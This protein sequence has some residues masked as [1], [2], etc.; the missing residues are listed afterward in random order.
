MRKFFAVIFICLLA[1]CSPATENNL[2]FYGSSDASAGAAIDSNSFIVAD[3]EENILKGYK[4]ED[5][6]KP[7]FGLDVSQ[8]LETTKE[9]P[10]AD[11][12]AAAK[13]GNRIYWITSHGRNKDGKLR[14]S[15]Y[16]FFATEFTADANIIKTVR[17]P[18]K[19]LMIDLLA[20]KSDVQKD[21]SE[22]AGFGF[23][24]KGKSAAKLAPKDEGLNIEGL[25]AS[26]DGKTLY[27]GF[28]NPLHKLVVS[29]VE[30]KDKKELAIVMPLKN[31]AI[32]I[33][34]GEK[35]IFGKPLLW[36]L[37]GLAI[38]DITYSP[39]HKAFKR[40]TPGSKNWIAVSLSRIYPLTVRYH[41]G[42]Q[43]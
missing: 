43:V 13:V 1:S 2:T 24:L 20:F 17:K 30:P 6:T 42:N 10:E 11:I 40:R 22:A 41:F 35:A 12:E 18:Y 36:D 31:P 21:L 4:I 33:E 14:P 27:I 23:D 38:R 26:A 7:V 9:N 19:D 8:F 5:G 34:K 32:V 3:D 29:E 15:R 39:F 25:C 37:D 28:R 16:R